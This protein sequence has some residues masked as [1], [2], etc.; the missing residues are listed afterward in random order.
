MWRPQSQKIHHVRSIV[1][2]NLDVLLTSN[3]LL[4]QQTGQVVQMKA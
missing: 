1:A 3:T 2:Y 4:L